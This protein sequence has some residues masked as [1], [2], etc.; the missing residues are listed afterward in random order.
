M[1]DVISD[2]FPISAGCYQ[3]RT[4]HYDKTL[5]RSQHQ[6][7]IMASWC[8]S[9][10][11]SAARRGQGSW[12]RGG[13][14][15]ARWWGTGDTTHRH[16]GGCRGPAAR[17]APSLWTRSCRASAGTSSLRGWHARSEKPGSVNMIRKH[18]YYYVTI[19][20]LAKLIRFFS[21]LFGVP[22]SM[23]VRSER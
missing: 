9:G 17:P 2:H 20:I 3:T 19:L 11:R 5:N 16:K 6:D 7:D 23:K 15:G 22:S 21:V 4:L 18:F 10:S 1:F 13:R 8:A 12:P 14:C